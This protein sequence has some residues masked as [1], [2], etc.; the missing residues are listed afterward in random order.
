MSTE[1]INTSSTSDILSIMRELENKAPQK[2]AQVDS[3]PASAP[4]KNDSNSSKE[5][6]P[7]SLLDSLQK[8]RALLGLIDGYANVKNM[9]S[10]KKEVNDAIDFLENFLG[11]NK[12]RCES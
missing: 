10:I 9:D 2:Q 1:N 8:K 6:N 4:V 3:S 5:I 11:N 12:A 7:V